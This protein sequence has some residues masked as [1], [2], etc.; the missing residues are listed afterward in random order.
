MPAAANAVRAGLPTP[1]RVIRSGQAVRAFARFTRD[2]PRDRVTAGQAKALQNGFRRYRSPDGS[3][4][5]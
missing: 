1:D 4:C 3:A 5:S 2:A